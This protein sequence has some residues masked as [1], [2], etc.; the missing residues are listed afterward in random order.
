MSRRW[1]RRDVLLAAGAA[2]AGSQGAAGRSPR[3]PAR[4]PYVP[5]DRARPLIGLYNA[6]DC[7]EHGAVHADQSLRDLR[8]WGRAW[9]FHDLVEVGF[10]W[11]RVRSIRQGSFS[12]PQ[13]GLVARV[14]DALAGRS[15]A[16]AMGTVLA[17][18][19]DYVAL[20]TSTHTPCMFAPGDRDDDFGEGCTSVAGVAVAG[21]AR[22]QRFAWDF[23]AGYDEFRRT[24]PTLSALRSIGLVPH[25][26]LGH[27]ATRGDPRPLAELRI[28]PDVADAARAPGE[29]LEAY[30]ARETLSAYCTRMAQLA[31]RKPNWAEPHVV[32]PNAKYWPVDA[33]PAIPD[34]A[35]R[36]QA[37]WLRAHGVNVVDPSD[38]W[39]G[40]DRDAARLLT[41]QIAA[42]DGTPMKPWRRWTFATFGPEWA[43]T[44]GGVRRA[45]CVTERVDAAGAT[46]RAE[47]HVAYDPASATY[48]LP[49]APGDATAHDTGN[50]LAFDVRI[51]GDYVAQLVDGKATASTVNWYVQGD[52]LGTLRITIGV[53]HRPGARIEVT[54]SHNRSA[55]LHRID[56]FS[57]YVGTGTPNGPAPGAPAAR[58]PATAN[59]R[60]RPGFHGFMWQSGTGTFVL[61]ALRRGATAMLGLPASPKSFMPEP[62]VIL[63]NA[64]LTGASLGE[65]H[66]LSPARTQHEIASAGRNVSIGATVFGDWMYAPYAR[67]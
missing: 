66:V 3:L 37:R 27:P 41:V 62:Q 63:R 52:G 60:L 48:T 20:T 57:L 16:S 61:E 26:R 33:F 18:Y 12:N 29:S 19:P 28:D 46:T 9:G 1:T 31:M 22:S 43:G 15:F 54:R 11:P 8:A 34:A 56:A 65:A 14:P 5:L 23:E 47:R 64:M 49:A 10:S 39:R 42:P 2:V 45:G 59:L 13:F 50:A 36:L 4:V 32:I 21:A 35:N 51:D 17:R 38:A 25:G 40:Y 44:T 53:P 55:S 7:R 58:Y 6:D 24:P 67:P 30:Y